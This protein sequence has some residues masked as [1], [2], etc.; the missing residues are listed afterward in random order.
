M[1]RMVFVSS[2]QWVE[3]IKDKV[4]GELT[5]LTGYTFVPDEVSAYM[6]DDGSM[7]VTQSVLTFYV[8]ELKTGRILTAKEITDL[9]DK[10]GSRLIEARIR[11]QLVSIEIYTTCVPAYP[12]ACNT[13]VS[14]KR[15][16]LK[17]TAQNKVNWEYNN[18]YC[19]LH[20]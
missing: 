3:D 13:E 11:Y 4:T 6:K 10:F 9:V 14:V 12:T 16:Y 19:N 15:E 7:D 18:M 5:N 8:K 2:E 1:S 20:A 17:F